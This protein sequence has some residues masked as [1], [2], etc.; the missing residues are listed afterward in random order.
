MSGNHILNYILS[1]KPSASENRF[2]FFLLDILID[3]KIEIVR[4]FENEM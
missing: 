1:K 3:E 2:I 4:Y